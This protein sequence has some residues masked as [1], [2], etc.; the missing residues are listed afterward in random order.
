VLTVAAFSVAGMTQHNDFRTILTGPGALIAAL[1]AV[2]GFVPVKSL[3]LA[4][5][6]RG[7]LGAVMRIDLS[8]NLIAEIDHLAEVVATARPDAV[9]AVVVDADGAGCS[10]CTADHRELVDAL[11]VAL[12]ELDITLADAH[13]VDVIAR[14]GRW[15]CA[16]G[17]GAQGLI[18]DPQVSPLAAAAVLE[19]R[20]LYARRE[21]LTALIAID[22]PR[23][24]AVLAQLIAGCDADSEIA[25]AD[26]DAHRT[27]RAVT[28][29][30]DTAARVAAGAVLVD[31]EMAGLGHALTD[32][33]TRDILYA[34]A[35]GELAQEA[36]SLWAVLARTLPGRSRVEALVL[37][38]FSAYARGDGP[39]AGIAL[40]EA[41]RCD[42]AH[43]MA[44][45]LD[46]A[47]HAAMRPD[48]IRELAMTG[49]RL[50]GRIGIELPARAATRRRA[51]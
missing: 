4:S 41:V 23:R 11:A 35:V 14:G 24:T 31:A 19:G 28:S 12:G 37:L 22:D 40:E 48:R 6:E 2:L 49:Y 18:E 38:A 51:G 47:L 3:V 25:G 16:D 8:E 15:Y 46:T 20:R 17:C 7:E 27:R 29:V 21:E 34:L 42:P 9:V 32:I 33:D 36:E 44:T 39:L 43:R 13:V 26:D 30:I 50:A 1:P 5:I 45:M 10:S